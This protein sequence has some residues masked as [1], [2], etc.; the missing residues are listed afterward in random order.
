MF[1]TVTAC[2]DHGDL[3]II[4]ST[5]HLVKA[6]NTSGIGTGGED[7]APHPNIN[8]MDQIIVTREVHHNTPQHL[9]KLSS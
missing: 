8:V 2:M 6:D 5:Q 1:S 4:F 3:Q 7:T 9:V